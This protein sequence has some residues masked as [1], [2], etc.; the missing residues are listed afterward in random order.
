MRPSRFDR[1]RRFQ[2]RLSPSAPSASANL[3]TTLFIYGRGMPASSPL[4]A[5]RQRRAP[6]SGP[7]PI[8]DER[9]ELIDYLRRL[10]SGPSRSSH[11]ANSRRLQT[12]RAV[13]R[14]CSP[15]TPSAPSLSF[16]LPFALLFSLR[17]HRPFLSRHEGRT[18]PR[19]GSGNEWKTSDDE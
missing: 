13:T 10:L 3:N 1:S 9:R 6:R 8:P 16:S 17:F 11:G 2:D 12:A 19:L 14:Y 4:L 18:C 7:D 15:I 5:A